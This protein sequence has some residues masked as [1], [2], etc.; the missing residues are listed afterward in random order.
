MQKVLR[1]NVFLT[2]VHVLARLLA[3]DYALTFNE[4]EHRN[5]VTILGQL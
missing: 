3:F 4:T 1:D 2:C 5:A